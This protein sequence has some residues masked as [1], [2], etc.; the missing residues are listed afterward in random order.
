[1]VF[2]SPIFVFLF[3]P[4]TGLLYFCAPR[5]ARNA[6]LLAASLIFYAWGEQ[7]FVFVML[8]SILLN[9]IFGLILEK[10]RGPAAARLVIAGAVAV[11]IGLLGF[12]KYSGFM[13]AQ[14]NS[15]TAMGGWP[16]VNFDAPHLPLGISFF[17]FHA[18]SYVIDVYRRDAQAQKNPVDFAL[19]I[20]FFPQ[21]IAGPIIRY[22]DICDQLRGRRERFD[23]AVSGVERALA[24]F[25]KKMILANPLGEIA[26]RAFGL[27]GDQLGTGVAWLGIAAY[28]LQIYLDFSGYSDMAIGLA[29]VF[30]FDFLENFNYPYR[31]RSIQEFWRR[32]HISL[33]NWFRDY[34]YIPLGGNR[35]AEWRI[36]LNLVIVFLVCGFWHGAAWTFVLWGALHGLFLVLERAGLG[37]VLARLPGFIGWLYAM[38][39]VVLAWVFF[40]AGDL[41]AA[42]AYLAAMLGRGPAGEGALAAADL[43]DAQAL[44]ALV[45]GALVSAGVF[46]RVTADW[47]L[48][49]AQSRGVLHPGL[50]SLRIGAEG[51]TILVLRLAAL[52]A[53]AV[54]GCAH[55]AASTY[56][57]FIYFRF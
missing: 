27:P 15:L 7:L 4:L 20:S 5:P 2:S 3:L 54:V 31:A 41:G 30:G 52:V 26:D 1:M 24:G 46:T 6:I 49:A 16:A 19:Y 21:L 40:R 38:A 39:V 35:V 11:N 50:E 29:R 56:N 32:W 43:I 42:C 12:Y 14:F 23:L 18:L 13:V 9:W 44:L 55:M 48:R 10:Y 45:T 57:P 37:A 8:A 25:G 47:R 28:S 17:T 51:T 22:H 33:S 53:I 34:L 36:W